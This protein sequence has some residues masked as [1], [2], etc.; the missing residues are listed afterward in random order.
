MN[1]DPPTNQFVVWAWIGCYL[2]VMLVMFSWGQEDD[3]FTVGFRGRAL[4]IVLPVLISF[5][6]LY[7]GRFVINWIWVLRVIYLLVISCLIL[8][9]V[10]FMILCI[11]FMMLLYLGKSGFPEFGAK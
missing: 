11:T 5:S 1:E 3:W 7:F 2:S 4:V 9:G 8:I 6:I 10:I